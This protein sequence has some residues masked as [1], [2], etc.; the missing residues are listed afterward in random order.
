MPARVSNGIRITSAGAREWMRYPLAKMSNPKPQRSRI[1]R[2][3]LLCLLLVVLLFG[4]N[5]LHQML[6]TGT[7]FSHP[8]Q[9]WA[10]PQWVRAVMFNGLPVALVILLIGAA[11]DSVRYSAWKKA[12]KAK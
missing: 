6:A 9:G 12:T 3:G 8:Q 1:T 4:Y 2:A 7:F 5:C 11:V 10:T